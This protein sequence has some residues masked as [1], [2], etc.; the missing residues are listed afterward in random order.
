LHQ[1]AQADLGAVQTLTSRAP[2]EIQVKGL[3]ASLK[4]VP[5]P[6]PMPAPMFVSFT[7]STIVAGKSEQIWKELADAVA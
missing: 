5:V 7:V 1:L 2:R 3:Y 4:A 6:E